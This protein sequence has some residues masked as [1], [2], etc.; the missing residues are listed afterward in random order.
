MTRERV[1]LDTNVLISGVLSRTSTTARCVDHVVEEAQLIASVA[2]L[3]ELAATLLSAKFDRF[4]ARERRESLLDRLAPII[5][6]VEIVQEFHV[7]QDPDDDK[8]LDL[9]V[10][11][12][13]DVLVSGDADL[14]ALHP[15]RGIAIVTPTVY[16]KTA[17]RSHG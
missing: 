9:A 4:V 7:C 2:T 5:E 14:L 11:G 12:R 3:R 16:L 6:I 10:N 13:V 1:V 8:F 15:F 17:L